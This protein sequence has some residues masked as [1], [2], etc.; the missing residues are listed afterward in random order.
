M[1]LAY[2]LPL[3]TSIV[4]SIQFQCQ[5]SNLIV[6][7]ERIHQYMDI[8]SEAPPVLEENRPPVNWPTKGK[9]DI[10]DLQVNVA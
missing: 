6:S 7:A 3:T 2:G 1:A 4:F 10:Q 5:V 8:P 9:V